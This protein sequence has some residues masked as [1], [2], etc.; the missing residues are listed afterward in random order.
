[1]RIDGLTRRRYWT[2]VAIAAAAAIAA[3]CL[4]PLAGSTRLDLGRALAHQP[5]DYEVLVFLRIPRVLLAML[6]G[7]SLSLAGAIFQATVRDSLATEHTMGV[8]SGASLGAVA[9]ICFGWQRI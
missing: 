2:S 3:L 6:V 5:P 9:A 4:T 7:G 1:M 8:S